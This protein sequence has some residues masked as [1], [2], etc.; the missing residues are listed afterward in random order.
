MPF[1]LIHREAPDHP[2][3]LAEESKH[4]SSKYRFISKIYNL[5][6]T[7]SSIFNANEVDVRQPVCASLST[8]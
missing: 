7:I 1:L 2:P 5:I 6:L 3:Y 8:V 4:A